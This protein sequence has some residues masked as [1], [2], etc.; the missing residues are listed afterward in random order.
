MAFS[1]REHPHGK[2]I[3]TWSSNSQDSV[4]PLPIGTKHTLSWISGVLVDLSEYPIA[5]PQLPHAY[6]FIVTASYFLLVGGYLFYASSLF[7]ARESKFKHICSL[8]SLSSKCSVRH[9]VTSISAG[10]TASCPKARANR[11]SS[12]AV[13]WEVLYAHSEIQVCNPRGGVNWIF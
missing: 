8:F 11:V 6:F 5:Y 4:W 3:G 13:F 7:S 2:P 9:V 1:P 10:T 12:V